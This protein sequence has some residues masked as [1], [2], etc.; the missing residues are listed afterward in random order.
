MDKRLGFC[1]LPRCREVTA[2]GSDEIDVVNTQEV[3]LEDARDIPLESLP[4]HMPFK[5]CFF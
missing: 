2:N 4:K 5:D 1:F 3:F